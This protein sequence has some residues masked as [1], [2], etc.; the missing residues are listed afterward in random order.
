MSEREL[1]GEFAA[2]AARSDADHLGYAVVVAGTDRSILGAPS[3]RP[4]QQGE[5]LTVDAG[6]V[7]NGYWV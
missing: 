5:L 2:A 1:L 7:S 3:D 4:W 6:V